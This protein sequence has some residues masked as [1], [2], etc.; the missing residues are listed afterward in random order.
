MKKLFFLFLLSASSILAQDVIIDSVAVD[1]YFGDDLGMPKSRIDSMMYN[2]KQYYIY[3][4]VLEAEPSYE[5]PK[6]SLFRK[7]YD[8]TEVAPMDYVYDGYYNAN[9]NDIPPVLDSLPEGEYL[10]LQNPTITKKMRKK[11]QTPP[12]IVRAIFSVKR[13]LLN[14]HAVFYPNYDT[15]RTKEGDFLNGTKT[16]EWKQ[17][18][19]CNGKAYFDSKNYVNGKLTGAFKECNCHDTILY[20]A[21]EGQYEDDHEQGEIKKY[22]YDSIHYLEKHYYATADGYAHYY[23][24]YNEKGV[25]LLEVTAPDS[26]FTMSYKY[27][28]SFYEPEVFTKKK[29]RRK[30]TEYYDGMY[31]GLYS[32]YSSLSRTLPTGVPF[33]ARYYNGQI[34]GRFKASEDIDYDTLY[35]EN[36]KIGIIRTVLPDT[37]SKKRYK[38]ASFDTLGKIHSLEY[39]VQSKRLEESFATYERWGR[40]KNDSLQLEYVDYSELLNYRSKKYNG[41][42]LVLAEKRNTHEGSVSTYYSTVLKKEFRKVNN[43]EIGFKID[44]NITTHDTLNTAYQ[45]IFE[46]QNVKAVVYSYKDTTH[47]YN[48]NQRRISPALFFERF[49]RRRGGRMQDSL[50]LFVDGKPF[51]GKLTAGFG[52][53]NKTIRNE[54]GELKINLSPVLKKKAG[55]HMRKMMLSGSYVHIDFVDGRATYLDLKFREKRRITKVQAQLKNS[56]PNG[57]VTFKQERIK[58]MILKKLH[59]E[60]SGNFIDGMPHGILYSYRAGKHGKRYLSAKET[61][62]RGIRKDTSYHYY[63]NEKLSRINVFDDKGERVYAAYYDFKTGALTSVEDHRKSETIPAFSFEL[64]AKGDTVE[65]STELNGKKHGRAYYLGEKYYY[66]ENYV[67]LKQENNTH[68]QLWLNYKDDKICGPVIYKDDFGIKRVELKVDSSYN[69]PTI[70]RGD[71][72]FMMNSWKEGACFDFAGEVIFYHPT[73]QPYFKG[74]MAYKI[75][76]P[77]VKDSTEEEEAL[78]EYNEEYYYDRIDTA[79]SAASYSPN[80]YKIGL[81]TYFD[82][83]GIKLYEIDYSDTTDLILGKDTTRGIAIYKA[84]YENG[85]LRYSGR[86]LE[87]ANMLDCESDLPERDFTVLYDAYFAKDGAPLVTKG[88]GALKIFY[89]NEMVRYEGEVINGQK[90][91]WWKEY[92]KEGKIIGAGKYVNGIKQGRWLYGDLTGINY[93]DDRCF[94]SEDMKL[95]LQQMVQY[96]L[97]IREEVYENG[98]IVKEE[99]YVFRRAE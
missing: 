74:R 68:D 73:R 1:G 94:E 98:E 34:L 91:G 32:G 99:N 93:L 83:Q 61:F 86:L 89:N 9:S 76:A 49:D 50:V 15:N 92:N 78:T 75:P 64:D 79:A 51:T 47:V 58:K 55:R 52:T 13:G 56:V 19:W 35:R 8:Y 44:F 88:T 37:L 18:Y 90:N 23:Y 60:G 33:V 87:E 5:E 80:S 77:S 42:T 3:P 41:P 40:D 2:G 46:L 20:V 85:Q 38:T 6:R 4:Y 25:K 16:G 53:G 27:L 63:S 39:M 12:Q 54:G 69:N 82:P 26:N 11:K 66:G 10:L 97:E 96:S 7:N 62:Q 36:G 59:E 28:P 31:D 14:G 45:H 71:L 48:E 81:W 30:N 21:T 72:A 43:E 17:Y 22:D 29:R 67:P 70:Y 95:Y 84:F 57:K 24:S 65:Y